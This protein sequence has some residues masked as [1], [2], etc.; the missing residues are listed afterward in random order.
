MNIPFIRQVVGAAAAVVLLVCTVPV[1]TAQQGA[2]AGRV[3]DRVTQQPV[4]GAEQLKR[5]LGHTVA[6]IDAAKTVEQATPTNLADLLNARAPG[7][8]V[9]PSG[10]TTGTGSRIRIRGSSSLSLTNEPII[11][12]DGIRVENGATGHTVTA[13]GVGGQTPS[14]LN[15]ISPE[16]IESIEIVKGPSA[17]ALYGTDAANGVIQIRTKRGRPG[18]TKWNGYVEGGVLND[19]TAWPAND[20][21]VT[22]AGASC[23]LTQASAGVCAIDTVRTFNPLEVNSPFQTGS[24]QQYGVSA[25]GGSEVTT[26]F[27]SGDFE[28]E[29]G[30]YHPNDLRRTSLRANLHH[31][32][33]RLLDIAVSTG[34]TSSNL[35]L[36][37]NDNNSAGIASSGL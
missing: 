29:K 10:G 37:Q 27:L 30:V 32:A 20:T 33:S 4:I 31:T 28:R 13:I 14:R 16:D 7:V 9:L 18:P 19:S 24:R 21:S 2:I 22:N 11:V 8:Q 34:Y 15:D 6:T 25:S 26:F 17:A 12:V 23:S 3:T 1:A 36:P 35:G 5:E